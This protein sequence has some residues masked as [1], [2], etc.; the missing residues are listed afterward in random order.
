MKRV[1]FLVL[2]AAFAPRLF[3]QLSFRERLE[4]L[5]LVEGANDQF[6]NAIRE[7]GELNE[8]HWMGFNSRF[9]PGAEHVIDVPFLNS[10][11]GW[12]EVNRGTDLHLQRK[13]RADLYF[14]EMDY[15]QHWQY[16]FNRMP[17]FETSVLHIEPSAMDGEVVVVFARRSLNENSLAV[18]RGAEGSA[19]LAA[20]QRELSAFYPQ[21]LK[22]EVVNQ[23]VWK[24]QRV[25]WADPGD[26]PMQ[27]LVQAQNSGLD[28]PG[29]FSPELWNWSCSID[30]VKAVDVDGD[31]R[32]L[33][34]SKEPELV[35]TYAHP[36]MRNQW[37]CADADAISLN[38]W[39]SQVESNEMTEQVLN[40]S[41]ARMRFEASVGW[42]RPPMATFSSGEWSDALKNSQFQ[43][44][45]LD[46][47]L[48]EN[49]ENPRILSGKRFGI[50]IGSASEAWELDALMMEAEA[51]DPDG[52]AYLRR[53]S[54]TG[55]SQQRNLQSASVYGGFEHD[56]VLGASSNASADQWAMGIRML[57]GAQRL[58]IQNSSIQGVRS[59]SGYYE[60][61]FGVEFTTTGIYDFGTTTEQMQS[62]P[63]LEWS[64]FTDLGWSGRF[65]TVNSGWGV[66]AFAGARGSLM[67]G[68]EQQFS[69][70]HAPDLALQNAQLHR[71][72]PLFSLGISKLILPKTDPTCPNPC[73]L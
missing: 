69:V 4:I 27:R 9:I 6:Q 70:D 36:S 45:A 11:G 18:V 58:K 19:D 34:I 15:L 40:F 52:D 43:F 50:A 71:I 24:I 55:L 28:S 42:G 44:T 7:G 38:S 23:G 54:W 33:L 47:W 65:T 21:I 5:D 10:R 8:M 46:V 35:A 68:T 16:T 72:T 60:D 13:P 37:Q 63:Q 48:T 57:V 73:D 49:V 62:E 29:G 39:L 59:I 22:Y 2:L 25:T 61:L 30:D 56:W 51:E 41:P 32:F 31:G 17:S 26:L 64:A 12:V 66:S 67:L 1:A 53:V 14:G 20:M 3:G